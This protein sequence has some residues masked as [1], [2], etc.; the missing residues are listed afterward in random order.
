M[1]S[2]E[3]RDDLLRHFPTLLLEDKDTFIKGGV[4]RD[5][6]QTAQERHAEVHEGA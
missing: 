3:T 1:L 2:W 4:D 6:A 5:P